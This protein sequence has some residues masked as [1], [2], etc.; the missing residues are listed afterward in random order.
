MH[1]D[2][3]GLNPFEMV[4]KTTLDLIFI[5]LRWKEKK[6]LIAQIPILEVFFPNGR[7]YQKKFQ[8]I[9]LMKLGYVF[10]VNPTT[11]LKTVEIPKSAF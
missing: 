4:S 5:I 9:S 6:I 10:F 2:N 3:I 7:P 11:K 1:L 8:L